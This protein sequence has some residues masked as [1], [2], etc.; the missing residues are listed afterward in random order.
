MKG[1]KLTSTTVLDIP[2]TTIEA[3]QRNKQILIITAGAMPGARQLLDELAHR[4]TDAGLDF[5]QIRSAGRLQLRVRYA[6]GSVRVQTHRQAALYAGL[7]GLSLDLV[8]HGDDVLLPEILPALLSRQGL[9]VNYLTG[10]VAGPAA[11]QLP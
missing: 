8:L 2:E 11:G 10:A 6:G 1:A 7:R 3:L 4:A 9:A 5:E